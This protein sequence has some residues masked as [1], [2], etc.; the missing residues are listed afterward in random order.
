MKKS[1]IL[2]L[3]IMFA[4]TFYEAGAQNIYTVAGDGGDNYVGDSVPAL[5]AQLHWPASLARDRAGNLYIADYL[6]NVVRKVDVNGIITTIAGN[7]FLNGSG[8]GDFSGDGG[9]ATAAHLWDPSGVCVDTNRFVYIADYA[10]NRVRMVDTNGIITT[11]AG[12]GIAGYSG[13]GGAAATAQLYNPAKVALDTFGDLYIVDV[14]NNCIRAMNPAGVIITIAGNA[15]LAAGYSGDGAASTA[16]Q[17]NSPADVAIDLTGDLYIADQDNNVI[18][19]VSATTGIISTFA[20]AGSAGF[21]GDGGTD[22]TAQFFAPSGLALDDSGNLFISD[23]GN[24]RIRE[25]NLTTNIINTV[26]GDG[27]EGFSGDDGPATAA[28]IWSP[29]GLV[30]DIQGGLYIADQGNNRIRFLSVPSTGAAATKAITENISL[31][32]NPCDGVFTLYIPAGTGGQAGV[33]IVNAL[34][35]QVKEFTM[36]TNKQAEVHLDSP[37]GI[38]FITV[39]TASGTWNKVISKR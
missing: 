6:N 10:N 20:G 34:G 30:T 15:T 31:Y 7:G 29:Q 14:K 33:S 17:L 5:S 22:T 9:P 1:F 8:E 24:N 21:R 19:Y 3:T 27:T 32:P 38:Y 36:A 13:D 11:I 4:F 39:T 12:T 37:A 35:E 28:E 23:Y 25:I 18:R 2:L 16:A 26:A